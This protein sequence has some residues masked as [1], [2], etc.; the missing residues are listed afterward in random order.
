MK[1]RFAATTNAGN[2]TGA[3]EDHIGWNEAAGLFVVADGMGGHAAGEV[4]SQI[5]VEATLKWAVE[6]RLADSLLK[7]HEAVVAAALADERREGM[8][9]TVVAFRRRDAGAEIGWVGD[10]R[11]YLLRKGTLTA[12]TRDHSLTRALT[13]RLGAAAGIPE[14]RVLVQAIGRENPRPDV[15]F[16]S[17]QVGD[18]FLLATDGLTTEVTE[19]EI[20][21]TLQTASDPQTAVDTLLATALDHGG[22]D[23][24]SIIVIE[25]MGR[26][27]E[28]RGARLLAL[29]AA[30]TAALAGMLLWLLM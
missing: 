6:F 8:G 30:V 16:Q 12:L 7:A 3:N 17:I 22:G 25:A 10:S 15:V 29:A 13:E 18:I 14:S 9:S 1:L 21:R 19:Q 4:A 24:V 20:S 23:N 27:Y 26:W 2:R 11:G 28:G 5:T